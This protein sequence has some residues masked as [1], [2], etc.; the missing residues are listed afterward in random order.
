[1]PDFFL[2]GFISSTWH[3]TSNGMFAGS[4]IG[5]ILLV[6]TLEF[7]RRLVREFDRYVI[8]GKTPTLTRSTIHQQATTS[9]PGT[10]LKPVAGN[11]SSTLANVSS[12]S[13]DDQDEHD[14]HLSSGSIQRRTGRPTLLQ[15]MARAFLHMAHLA[16]AYFIMLLAMYFN[17]YIIICILIGAFIG[18]FVFSWDVG[19]GT[20]GE[21]VTGCCG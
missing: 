7:I 16:V 18:A 5:V 9:S 1:M 21:E 2:L 19:V 12:S 3:I 8:L 20:A 4:C 11:T 15:Q 13:S 14:I 6:C 10:D 17:G